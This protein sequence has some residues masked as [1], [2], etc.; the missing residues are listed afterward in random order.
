VAVV[1]KLPPGKTVCLPLDG[2]PGEVLQMVAGVLASTSQIL[3]AVPSRR[4]Q[5]CAIPHDV[6]RRGLPC[7]T[8]Q[9]GGDHDPTPSRGARAPG[10]ACRHTPLGES[11]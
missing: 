5:Y 6:F 9:G 2:Q 11:S 10:C 1:L 3:S 8:P 4:E 7:A